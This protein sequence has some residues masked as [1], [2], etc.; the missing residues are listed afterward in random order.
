MSMRADVQEIRLYGEMGRRFG[1]VHHVLLDTHTPAEAV[2]YLRSQ[3]SDID[4]YLLGAQGRGIGF[5]VF[6]GKRNL[7]AEE[8]TQSVS[9]SVIRIA[10]IIIGSK[11]GGILTIIMGVVLVVVGGFISGWTMGAGSGVGGYLMGMGISMIAGGIVQLLS[12]TPKGLKTGDGPQNDPSYSFAGPV[13]T[14]A[15]G[16]PI[17]VGYGRVIT[18]SAVA[19]AGIVAEDY[20]PATSGVGPGTPGGGNKKNYYEVEA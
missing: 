15:Q 10:P 20:A 3:F 1:R 19:S 2:S 6:V 7:T 16:N 11:N 5:S 13:N 8:L 4:G 9:D 12:P 18:G 14:Q 17:Q